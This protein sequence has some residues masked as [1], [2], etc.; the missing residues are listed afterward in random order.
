[1]LG[2]KEYQ[3]QKKQKE[4]YQ[5]Q[6]GKPMAHKEQFE[7]I[8]TLKDKFP[9]FFNK[10]KVLDVGSLNINGSIRQFFTDC[11]YLGIDVGEGPC[12]DLVVKGEEYDAPDG[13]YD[14]VLSCECLEHNPQWVETFRNMIRLVKSGGA[15]IMTCATTGR[16]EHGTIRVNPVDSPLTIKLGWDYYRNLTVA[17]FEEHFNFRELFQNHEFVVNISARDLYFFGIRK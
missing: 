15:I 7:Y 12:V 14:V 6:K 11:Y 1:L 10:V 2:I 17:D 9:R 4:K 5:I 3:D 8:Q 16:A 13:S